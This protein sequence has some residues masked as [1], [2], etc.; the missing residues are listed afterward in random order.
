M[1]QWITII[2]NYKERVAVYQA[3]TNALKKKYTLFTN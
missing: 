3:A 2:N 1:D